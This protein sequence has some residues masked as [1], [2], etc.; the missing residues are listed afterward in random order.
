M[1]QAK[2]AR[3]TVVQAKVAR[4]TV[5]QAKVVRNTVVQAAVVRTSAGCTPRGWAEGYERERVPSLR[6][7][8]GFAI[9][10][11]AYALGYRMPPLRG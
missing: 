2:V 7:S 6:D 4:D 8:G 5:V 3:V 9:F 1:V 11:S 10:P